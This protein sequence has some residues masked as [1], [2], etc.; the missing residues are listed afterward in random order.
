MFADHWVENAAHMQR[1]VAETAAEK[2]WHMGWAVL[3]DVRCLSS[4][5][6]Q[7]CF[8]SRTCLHLGLASPHF[9]ARHQIQR[10]D[11]VYPSAWARW[12]VW[13]LRGGD[14]SHMCHHGK[15]GVRPDGA[16]T[17]RAVEKTV[18]SISRGLKMQHDSDKY[19]LLPQLLTRKMFFYPTLP[20]MCFIRL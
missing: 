7:T 4:W 6:P 9:P 19:S 5:D 1:N 15:A 13:A 14:L 12:A 11:C 10:E 2:G 8:L 20:Q 17:P 3:E 18:K 16:M